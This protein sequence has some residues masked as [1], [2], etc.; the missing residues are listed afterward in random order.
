LD[1]GDLCERVQEKKGRAIKKK[2]EYRAVT[3]AAEG[4]NHEKKRET[5]MIEEAGKKPFQPK[6]R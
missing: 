2:R 6:K 3:L 5:K 1:V 4:Q